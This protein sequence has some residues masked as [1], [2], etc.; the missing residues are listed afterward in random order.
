MNKYLKVLVINTFLFVSLMFSF[1]SN[2]SYGQSN[3]IDIL[4]S[5]TKKEENLNNRIKDLDCILKSENQYRILNND[6][7]SGIL[8]KKINIDILKYSQ[9][10]FFKMFFERQLIN[11]EKS[12]NL[13]IKEIKKEKEA[14]LE[15]SNATYIRGE[16][17]LEN[18]RYISSG[19][20]YRIHPITK[21]ISFHNGIDIPA[22]QNTS[23]LASDDGIV[24]FAGYKSG[25][26]NVVEIEHFDNK[27]TLYAHNSHLIVEAGQIVKR[28]QVI[29]KVGS[30]GNSTGNHVHFEVKIN[31][32]SIN[33]LY[34]ISNDI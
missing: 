5:I 29:A 20:G 24:S 2:I 8:G 18:Y 7:E 23:V 17:P 9:I 13:L 27:K 6:I 25:Y 14:A 26:G 10:K 11:C 15:K 33:P 12:E 31:D 30:T 22:P 4:I 21:R 32:K 16:W 3:N 1:Q 28:G 19:Y 34:G